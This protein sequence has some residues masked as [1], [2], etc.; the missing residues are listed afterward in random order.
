MASDP[1]ES[2]SIAVS[3]P[4]QVRRV[5]LA[6]FVGTTVEWYD[7]FLFGTAAALVFP[8]VFFPESTELQ[9]TLKSFATYAVGFFARPIGGIIFGHFGDRI[10]RKAMLVTTLTMMGAATFLIGLLPGFSQIGMWAPGLLITMRIIQGFGVGG[11]WGG[12]VL[13]AV[14]HGGKKRRGFFASWVQ[15]GVPVGMLL[16]TGVFSI[17]SSMDE[18][19]FLSWG[20]RVPFLLGGLLLAIGMFIRMK[21]MESPIF[22]ELQAKRE[23]QEDAARA[24]TADHPT[25]PGRLP[26]LEV[27]Q[28][29]RREVLLAMGARF[30][31]NASYY[32]FTVISITFAVQWLGLEK[33]MLL[34]G[35]MIASAVQLVVIPLFGH[36]SDKIGRRPIYLAGAIATLLFAWPFFLM[37]ETRETWVIWLAITIG[38]V[39]HAMMYAPQAAF[40]SEMFG[41]GVRYTGASLGYQVASPLAGGLAPLICAWLLGKSDGDA[42]PLAIY[43]MIMCLVTL[44]AV[45]MAKE[46]HRS[47]L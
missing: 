12:A 22:A 37:F 27:L 44:V 46:T 23:K 28:T 31:E 11:E 38:L 3:D 4:K 6:S 40:F 36:L 19:A 33:P 42:F 25:R 10:G 9:G 24:G 47:D 34:R 15:A 5:V 39:I 26:L 16:A 18:A 14:E 21:V 1:L 17:F 13:M 32:I 7:Y 29:Q 8:H 20:W 30:A 41:T 43:L 35:I 45:W 2:P